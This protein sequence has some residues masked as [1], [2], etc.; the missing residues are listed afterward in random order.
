MTNIVVGG[1]P[2]KELVFPV[3]V[4][5]VGPQ[6][7]V[8]TVW[9]FL[10]LTSTHLTCQPLSAGDVLEEHFPPQCQSFLGKNSS[11]QLHMPTEGLSVGF[12]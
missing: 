2:C 9:W 5:R 7:A 6:R 3:G 12:C 8:H 1:S 10:S 11:I 4:P